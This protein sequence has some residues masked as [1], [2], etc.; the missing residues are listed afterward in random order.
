MLHFEQEAR[1]GDPRYSQMKGR[2]FEIKINGDFLRRK[3]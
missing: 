1:K 2:G 3:P